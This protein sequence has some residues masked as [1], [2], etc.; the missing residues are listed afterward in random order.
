[1]P[2][3]AKTA[4]QKLHGHNLSILQGN[5]C[6]QSQQYQSE[7]KFYFHLVL[8][9]RDWQMVAM[10]WNLLLSR[11]NEPHQYRCSSGNGKDDDDT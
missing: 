3:A 10:K 8:L 6:H 5:N 11:A 9:L 4:E 7:Y 1:M 2:G